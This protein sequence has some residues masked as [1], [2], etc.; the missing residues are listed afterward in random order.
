MLDLEKKVE[1]LMEVGQEIAALSAESTALRKQLTALFVSQ[2]APP[3]HFLLTD[4]TS[5]P[6]AVKLSPAKTPDKV[7]VIDVNVEIIRFEDI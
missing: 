6:F 7:S 1:R 3:K 2:D 4:S 5:S